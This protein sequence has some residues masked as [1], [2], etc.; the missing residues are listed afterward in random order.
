[1]W[2][3]APSVVRYDVTESSTPEIAAV[4]IA[5]MA[6]LGVG[7][8]SNTPF[9]KPI[10]NFYQT[11]P[12]SRAY[13]TLSIL[14]S[15]NRPD[16]YLQICDNGA[17]HEDMGRQEGRRNDDKRRERCAS[18]SRADSIMFFSPKVKYIVL[19]NIGSGWL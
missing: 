15:C 19:L 8:A 14:H 17:V 2:E 5:S 1:M 4:S 18:R 13:V 6:G 3:I 12:I 9:R 11:D 16:C 10:T 7:K